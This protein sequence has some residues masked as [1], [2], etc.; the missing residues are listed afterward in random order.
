MRSRTIAAV[1]LAAGGLLIPVSLAAPTAAPSLKLTPATLEYGKGTVTLS[2]VV[3]DKQAGQEIAILSQAC[4]FT[5]PAEIATVKSGPGGVFRF[6]VQPLLNTSFRARSNGATSA[7]VKVTV[8]PIV[9][10]EKLAAGRF[11]VRVLTTN[12]V[13]LNGKP[14]LLQRAVGTKWVT[15]K[16]A[17]LVKASPETE[18]TVVSAATIATRASGRLRAFVP[19]ARGCYLSAFSRTIGI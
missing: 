9:E 19:A 12:P 14:V 5:E 16:Q 15:F 3:P 13:F 18:I 11:R 1:A 17:T 4:L 6:R 8:R 7:P 10:F 2:G